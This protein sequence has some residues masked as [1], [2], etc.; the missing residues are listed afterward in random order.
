MKSII[1]TFIILASILYSCDI[2]EKGIEVKEKIYIESKYGTQVISNYDVPVIAKDISGNDI[3]S[4]TKFFIDGSAING[5]IIRFQNSGTYELTAEITI[6]GETKEA[7]PL[8][9][10]VIDPQS[11]TKILVEDFTGV[12]CVNCPRIA[13]KL[14]NAVNQ[15]NNIIP[16]AIHGSFNSST[17][18]DPFGYDNISYFSNNYNVTAYPTPLVNR[19]FVWDENFSTLENQ[20]NKN[21][22]MGLAINSTLN[23]NNIDI[24]VKVRF[25]MDFSSENLN[26]VVYLNENGLR[27]DQANSTNYYGGQNPIPNFEHNHTLRF[28]FTGESGVSINNHKATNEIYTYH[29]TGA[30][31]LNVSNINN[32]EIVAFV[33]TNDNPVKVINVQ[34]ATINTQQNFD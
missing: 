30:V 20:L 26:L 27:H 21:K 9:I 2:K 25:D 12:W 3:T 32:C 17:A 7:D 24:E 14:E 15:N 16:T 8:T 13:Y 31:P 22:P 18:F 19:D 33:A 34:K 1:V 5:N 28:T 4:Q 6:D 10:N 23:G 11:S 29:Y